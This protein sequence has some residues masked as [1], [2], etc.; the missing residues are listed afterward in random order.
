MSEHR[1]LLFKRLYGNDVVIILSQ[2]SFSR[3]HRAPVY[4]AMQRS[5][6]KE[7]SFLR[8]LN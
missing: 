7:Y 1:N 8:S 6:L 3:V 4:K 2:N 5:F